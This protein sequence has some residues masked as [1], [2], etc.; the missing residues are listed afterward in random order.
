MLTAVLVVTT[1]YDGKSFCRLSRLSRWVEM[2]IAAAR[3]A[4]NGESSEDESLSQL[5]PLWAGSCRSAV[6]HYRHLA[7]SGAGRAISCGSSAGK[8]RETPSPLKSIGLGPCLLSRSRLR[9]R[10]EE[11]QLP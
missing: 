9:R 10:R 4:R 1:Q 7:L 11:R 2:E 6:V 5:L 3:R 8:G